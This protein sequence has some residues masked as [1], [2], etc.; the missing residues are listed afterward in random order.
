MLWLVF[1]VGL[2]G[3]QKKPGGNDLVGF[4]SWLKGKATSQEEMLC[5]VFGVGLRGKQHKPGGNVLF[6]FGGWH[7]KVEA[8]K[9]GRQNLK[10]GCPS[11]YF[12]T[13]IQWLGPLK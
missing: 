7:E 10:F 1:G 5:L 4:W 8:K 9:P 13:Y 3:Q 6:G 2:R 12:G 11:S